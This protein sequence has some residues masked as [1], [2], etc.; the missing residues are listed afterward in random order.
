MLRLRVR[1]AVEDR[2]WVG[3]PEM[4]RGCVDVCDPSVDVR[5]VGFT[6]KPR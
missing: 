1:A 6:S 5:G 4:A 3:S 2:E